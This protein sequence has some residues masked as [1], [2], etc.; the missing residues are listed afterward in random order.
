MSQTVSSEH[1]EREH[2][3]VEVMINDKRYRFEHH[4]VTGLDIKK[5]ADIPDAYSLY[6]RH[7]GHNEPISDNERVELHDGEHFFSRPPSNVS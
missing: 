3:P 4:D 5:K 6:R 2:H 1:E 7:P